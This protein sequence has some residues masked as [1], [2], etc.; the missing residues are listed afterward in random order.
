MTKRDYC[1]NELVE[2]EKN[3]IEAL[4]MI[5]NV[6]YSPAVNQI[7]RRILWIYPQNLLCYLKPLF[8]RQEWHSDCKKSGF[9]NSKV[10][11]LRTSLNLE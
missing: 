1:I 8:D 7:L 6:S 5:I 4:A 3:Y 9:H 11:F 2:T 10:R